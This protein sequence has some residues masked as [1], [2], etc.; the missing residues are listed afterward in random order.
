MAK[1]SRQRS[2][3]D[4]PAEP[5]DLSA[6]ADRAG[7]TPEIAAAGRAEDVPSEIVAAGD[8]RPPES[9]A[10]QSVYVIDGHSL[11]YQLFHA[12]PEL[13][14]PGGEPVGAVFGF[15]RDLLYLLETK[16]PDY[17]FCAFDV[18]KT[19]RHDLYEPYK[20]N[21][22]SMPDDLRVQI[23]SIRELL[24][25]LGVPA[26]GCPGYEADDLLATIGRQADELG[27][28]CMLVTGDKDCRQLITDR[29]RVYN[30]RKDQVYDRQ[31]LLEEW[32][33]AP[34]QVVDFQTLVG[35]STD[36][37]PGVPL[38]GPKAAQQLLAQYG[39]LENLLDHAAE[40][41]GEK[42]RQNLMQCR[43]QA[44]L[45]RRLVRLDDR[46]PCPIPW[47]SARVGRIDRQRLAELFHRWGFRSMG[48][49]V[50]ALPQREAAPKKTAEGLTRVVDTPEALAEL[51]ARLR[52]QKQIAVDVETKCIPGGD[53]GMVWPCWATIVGIVLACDGSEGFYIPG[54]GPAGERC[55][56]L[57]ATL[58]ALRPVLED[59]AIEK[60]GQNLKYD[61]IVLRNAGTHVAGVAFDTMVASYLLDAGQRNHSLD[62]IAQRYLG[63]GKTSITELI[64]SGKNQ[65]QM[66]QVPIAQV[67][68][69]ACR[70]VMLPLR[71][72]PVLEKKLEQADLTRL[73]TDVEM[74][75]VEVLVE[76]EHNGIRID[77]QR[78]AAL[79]GRFGEQIATLEKEIYVLAGH[80][81]NIA[82]P[83]QLQQVLFTELSLPVVS[84][85][86][87]GPSTDADV[88]EELARQHPLPAKILE[89]R[90][91][92]KL[93]STYV[94]ALPLMVHP[95]TGRVHASFH[96]AVTATGRLSSSD[97][98]LQNIP[99]RTE[100]GR[101]IRSAFIPGEEGWVLLAADYSQIELRV[102]AHFSGDERL[103]EAFARDEDIHA[104]VAGR[105]YGVPQEQVTPDMRR[106]AKAVNFGVIYGQSAFGLARELGI[107]KDEAGK[108]IDNYFAGYPG[109]ERF[110]HQ[111]LAEC[112]RSGYVSTILGR[113]R[114]IRGVRAD[115]GRQRNLPERTAINTVIQG[116]A[117]D[118]I[119]LAMLAI[120]RR[121]HRERFPSRMLLQIHDELVFEVPS[122]RAGELAAMVAE[123]MTGVR[124]LEVPLKV[125]VKI[126]PNW[127]ETEKWK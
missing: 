16:K 22:P 62:E 118:L 124:R 44:M 90:Q 94:D 122:D 112:F 53:L 4:P 68:E 71:L 35:D 61:L 76:L 99:I 60:V 104:Q 43:E 113:Q 25:A 85:T 83:K 46:V 123:E 93:K 98:N 13:S 31:T 32:G 52:T 2:L 49:R 14:S 97:P 101:E 87:T 29:V 73:F 3:F 108:F 116:S 18:G 119:K 20:A 27:G 21:R 40:V 67:A 64:G 77:C 89:Y 80:E 110:L 28:E 38:I 63:E 37:V 66:D 103:A 95:Q 79:S 88:L 47:R 36:N 48:G 58:D 11:I 42:K 39:T 92:A 102:L 105:I 17:L 59:P 7:A 54:C 84:K 82:S 30:I 57:Q 86:K 70:D 109:I 81:F 91:C 55:L 125:D 15:A 65:K 5:T 127:A 74:P 9:L 106:Q 78:L 1:Q 72:R 51:V 8:E 121:L 34:E 12:L 115:A 19:F 126:G 26:I 45:T 96:Q 6:E 56:D 24:Q 120:H 23:A 117:A 114:A 69:Y 107:G 50:D 100:A 75:L 10:G 33:V 111:V 41:S